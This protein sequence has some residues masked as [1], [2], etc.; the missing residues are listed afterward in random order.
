ME[1]WIKDDM[2]QIRSDQSLSRVRLFATP[3]MVACQ[4]SLCVC[5]CV[6]VCV[7]VC[8]CVCMYIYIH[9]KMIKEN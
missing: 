4:A 8:V 1:V 3:W 9:I 7:Y 2:Y 6:C 5:V